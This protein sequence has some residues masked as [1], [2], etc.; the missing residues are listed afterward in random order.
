MVTMNQKSII[1]THTKRE[2]NANNT[3][4]SH[5]ITIEENKRR[6]TKGTKKTYK[7]NPRTINKM[8]IRIYIYCF[9]DSLPI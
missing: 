2:R 6:L 7:N 1:D 8:V 3:K 9:L 5:Q 4:D